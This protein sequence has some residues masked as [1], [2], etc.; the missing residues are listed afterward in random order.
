MDPNYYRNY[1]CNLE[2]PKS[3]CRELR[4][5]SQ[6]YIH[7][8][9]SDILVSPNA[10]FSSLDVTG[11][12]TSNSI[13]ATV[14]NTELLTSTQ[15]M[16]TTLQSHNIAA[17]STTTSTLS[18]QTAS[19][20]SLSVSGPT[21]L[22]NLTVS[23]ESNLGGLHITP[24]TKDG[25]V[26]SG[27]YQVGDSQ[28]S[29]PLP[30]TTLTSNF[31]IEYQTSSSDSSSTAYTAF[32]THPSGYTSAVS[33]DSGGICY[34]SASNTIDCV[35]N[36]SFSGEYL[37]L[38]FTTPRT[39]RGIQF[40]NVGNASGQLIK[41]IN[42]IGFSSL[43]PN[44]YY[45]LDGFVNL[46]TTGTIE[47]YLSSL[48]TYDSFIFMVDSLSPGASGDTGFKIANL[49]FLVY[50]FSQEVYIPELLEVGKT[51]D[52]SSISKDYN[53]IVNGTS[54]MSGDLSV[55]NLY[56]DNILTSHFS[57]TKHYGCYVRCNYGSSGSNHNPNNSVFFTAGYVNHNLLVQNFNEEPTTKGPFFE[58]EGVPDTNDWF[59]FKS[60]VSGWYLVTMNAR[61]SN[62]TP[63]MSPQIADHYDTTLW[64]PLPDDGKIPV[65]WGFSETR[66]ATYSGILYLP[67]GMRISVYNSEFTGTNK[68]WWCDLTVVLMQY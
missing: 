34:P 28:V 64:T 42:V 40:S 5:T 48:H 51:A 43:Q 15:I 13:I 63:D 49:N 11:T 32:G 66:F 22:N 33:Y 25:E 26:V 44:T 12:L 17:S 29:T 16:N 7:R 31:G 4:V 20:T 2:C 14:V 58:Y 50:T 47:R 35:G 24:N 23:T 19:V 37:R 41:S 10:Q 18:C 54:Y 6:A 8:L 1:V 68:W 52:E 36:L 53:F 65:S 3:K 67:K 45:H 56:V 38:Q 62:G 21:N 9:D 57:R 46:N 60:P 61:G 59:K 30:N 27:S 39:C 55:N